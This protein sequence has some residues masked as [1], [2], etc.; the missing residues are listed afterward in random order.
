MPETLDGLFRKFLCLNHVRHVGL[1]SDRFDA[2]VLA[3]PDRLQRFHLVI[4]VIDDDVRAAFCKSER[5]RTPDTT[6]RSGDDSSLSGEEIVREIDRDNGF[7]H[8]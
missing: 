4:E 5:G 6:R 1:H 2:F 8:V 7:V 3:E